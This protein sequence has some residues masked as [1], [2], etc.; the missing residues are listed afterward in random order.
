MEAQ[1]TSARHN[2]LTGRVISDARDKSIG[3]LI[4]RRVKH[5]VYGKYMRR[6]S[7]LHAHDEDNQAKVGDLVRVRQSR[8]IS[9]S[10]SWVLDEVV[11]SVSEA[12]LQGTQS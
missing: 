2:T 9:K 4:E 10:K 1:D 7:K 6:S 12:D 5:P 3:V 11:E 8:P